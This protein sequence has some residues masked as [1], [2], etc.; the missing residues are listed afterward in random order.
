MPSAQSCPSPRPPGCSRRPLCPRDSA[1]NL[2]GAGSS[3]P[4]ERARIPHLC[5]TGWG[6]LYHQRRREA[7]IQEEAPPSRTTHGDH[8][9]R[10]LPLNEG[11]HLT[12]PARARVPQT[13]TDG[14]RPPLTG[15]GVAEHRGAVGE[16]GA[17]AEVA[18]AA[19]AAHAAPPRGRRGLDFLAGAD[20]GRGHTVMAVGRAPGHVPACTV[21]GWVPVTHTVTWG[22]V[23]SPRH[24]RSPT[25]VGQSLGHTRS[26]PWAWPLGHVPASTVV[27]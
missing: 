15:L 24:A 6:L 22:W 2:A 20:C 3:P 13:G 14:L 19:A 23:G 21:V 9:V 12:K 7:P 25:A 5:C 11:I 1:G 18:A 16:G 8:P 27:G 10:P 26:R 17:A 4:R